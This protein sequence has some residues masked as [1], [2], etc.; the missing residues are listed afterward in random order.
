MWR[1]DGL[2]GERLMLTLSLLDG[3]TRDRTAEN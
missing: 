2:L 1:R 3:G